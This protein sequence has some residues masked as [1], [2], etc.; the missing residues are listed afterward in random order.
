M[1]I[2]K[3][4]SVNINKNVNLFQN[5]QHQIQ[6]KFSTNVYT[7][8]YYQ[9]Y[10]LKISFKGGRNPQD[11]YEYNKGRMPKTMNDYLHQNYSEHSNLAPVQLMSEAFDDLSVA[12]TVD[13][14]KELYPNE[15]KFAQL[16]PANYAAAKTGILRKIYEIKEMSENPEPLF[17]DGC[18]DLTTYI[19]KKIYLE[20]KTVKEIDKDFEKD[21]NPIYELAAK[22]I[23]TTKADK[24]ESKY[25]S[26]ST[27]YSLGIRFP[28]VD[29]WNS[30]I[31][32]RDDYARTKRIKTASGK[33]VNASSKEGIGETGKKIQKKTESL[34]RKYNFNK[35]NLKRLSDTIVNSKGDASKALKEVKHKSNNKDELTFLQQYWSPIMSIAT[36]KIHLS[37]E[38]I[39]FNQSRNQ[40]LQVSND[41]IDKF[42]NG[43][44]LYNKEK[45][46]MK[47]FWDERTDLKEHFSNA[48]SD[49]IILFTETFGADG[50]NKEFEDLLAYAASIKPARELQKLEHDK[51][52]AE[53]D[54]LA[55]EL[56][57]I[58]N[59]NTVTKVEEKA[60]KKII[61]QEKPV[62]KYVIN[63]EQVILPFDLEEKVNLIFKNE[64]GILPS[65]FTKTYLST[66]KQMAEDK[67]R[68]F[69]TCCFGNESTFPNI[70]NAVYPIEEI[71]KIIKEQ[72]FIMEEKYN[73]LLEASRFAMLI[74]GLRHNLLTAEEIRKYMSVDINKIQIDLREKLETD[75]NIARKEVE[76]IFNGLYTNLSSKEKNSVR[77]ILLRAI[78]NYEQN[79][80]YFEFYELAIKKILNLISRATNEDKNYLDITKNMLNSNKIY[81]RMGGVLRLIL[82]E[83]TTPAIKND[84]IVQALKQMLRQFPKEIYKLYSLYPE[85]YMLLANE[86]MAECGVNSMLNFT[87]KALKK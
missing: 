12:S 20:G 3:I 79:K 32:T 47:I 82:D 51:I 73:P 76:D 86:A 63:G 45:T 46:P 57:P 64:F 66:L 70:I 30:F 29:F 68:L 84:I 49:T 21:I 67:N 36:E 48:I 10:N 78:K 41:A 17:K 62:Y 59:G 65:K 58:D 1:I 55:E 50:K 24:N 15:E 54:K 26:N 28:K 33:F 56:S 60:E 83:N 37:E 7:Q 75:E 61:E 34:P 31:S 85:E 38:L 43:I 6:S 52:Q 9:D 39:D 44:A 8:G 71:T 25:F 80:A 16:K 87:K 53:Y 19:V 40:T 14:I 72:S 81:D 23:D 18:D 13:D 2:N 22:A 35:T 4:Q 11:F 42:I 5:K 27:T 74:Y 69:L 77:I